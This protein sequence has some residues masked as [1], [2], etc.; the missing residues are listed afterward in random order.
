[1]SS[2]T[3]GVSEIRSNRLIGR[4]C[5]VDS[6]VTRRLHGQARGD[7]EREVKE[8]LYVPRHLR[9]QDRSVSTGFIFCTTASGDHMSRIDALGARSTYH[10]DRLDLYHI[11]AAG[12]AAAGQ[13][14][15]AVVG[16]CCT[17]SWLDMRDCDCDVV[18]RYTGFF[19]REWITMR[20]AEDL[21]CATRKTS[22]KTSRKLVTSSE[23]IVYGMATQYKR[24]DTGG[25]GWKGRTESV[26]A[27]G[28]LDT[29]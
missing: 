22:R 10:N 12:A 20:R 6:R 5:A 19:G 25:V 8:L 29:F 24:V 11:V 2:R 27:D 18:V 15:A 3:R 16:P 17:A 28:S 26:G 7:G 14:A 9:L 4:S 23:G 1:M 21:R 13:L